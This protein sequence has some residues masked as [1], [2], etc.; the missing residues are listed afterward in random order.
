MLLTLNIPQN[1]IT[2]GPHIFKNCCNL[3][4]EVACMI[5]LLI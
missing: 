4:F 5:E 1:R 3:F 2:L